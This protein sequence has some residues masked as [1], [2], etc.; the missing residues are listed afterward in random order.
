MSEL[1]VHAAQSPEQR[2]R[3]Y[4]F[5]DMTFNKFFYDKD[6]TYNILYNPHSSFMMTNLNVYFSSQMTETLGALAEL[7]FSFLPMGSKTQELMDNEVEL[8]MT[9]GSV[10]VFGSHKLVDTTVRDPFTTAEFKLGGVG[11]ERLHLTWTPRDWFNVIAGRY[12]TPYGIWNVEHGSPVITTARLPYMQIREMAPLAQTGLQI[13]GR[14][15]PRDN[16]F[17]DYAVTL[18][19]GRGFVESMMDLDENKGLGLKMRLTY[20]SAKVRFQV[21]GYG[22]MGT[23]VERKKRMVM[24][25]NAEGQIDATVDNSFTTITPPIDAYDEYVATADLLLEAFGLT[26]QSEY[27]WRYVDYTTPGHPED[28]ETNFAGVEATDPHWGYASFTGQSVYCLLSYRL[29][30]DRWLGQFK[31]TPYVMYEYNASN[32]TQPYINVKYYI[33]GVNMKPSP[34][35]TLK[36]EGNMMD[37]KNQFYGNKLKAL[38]LQ[39]AVSF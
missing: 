38:M 28:T 39:M 8:H 7:R 23:Y 18:S 12:L 21:G 25:L 11:I 6:S 17:L 31:I 34:F 4:G 14:L 20:E 22:Y 9:D 2:F 15:F 13:Y 3:V 5:F 1:E 32:D 16:L 10:M 35:V 26:L 37:P 19:N 30:L 33:A 36:L 24:I 27:I 29:P